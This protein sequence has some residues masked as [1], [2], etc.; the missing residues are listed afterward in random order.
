MADSRGAAKECSPGRASL[1]ALPWVYIPS[2]K[3]RGAAKDSFAAPRLIELGLNST[4]CSRGYILSPLR[5][6]NHE[7]G[8]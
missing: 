2:F 6:W 4:A 8:T 5:G 7:A 1:R 3:S